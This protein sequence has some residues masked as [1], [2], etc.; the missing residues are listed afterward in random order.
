MSTGRPQSGVI[1][2]FCQSAVGRC[3]AVLILAALSIGCGTTQSRSATE[4]LLTS[5]A[6]DRSIARIDFR[7]LHGQKVFLDVDYVRNAKGVGSVNPDYI[8]S[9][10]RQQL[11]AAGCLLQENKHLA[12][13][14]VEPRVGAL[15]LDGHDVIYGIPAN[16]GLNAASALVPTMPSLPTIPELALAK[17]NDQRAASKIGVFAYHRV[18]REVVWQS[19]ISESLSTARDSWLM[20]AGPFQTGT[21]Y[22]EPKFVAGGVLIPTGTETADLPADVKYTEAKL[23][24]PPSSIKVPLPATASTPSPAAA[25]VTPTATITATDKKPEPATAEVPQEHLWQLPPTTASALAIP[26]QSATPA[27]EAS[28]SSTR[29]QR[30]SRRM[31]RSELEAELNREATIVPVSGSTEPAPFPD[32]EAIFQ[33]KLRA[34]SPPELQSAP[35]GK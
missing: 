6:V 18:T 4:Q 33:G 11:L 20:G 9:S 34:T 30:G 13:F 29:P 23:F 12:D 1:K 15:G 19:G 22:R 16:N 3:A 24:K 8:I 21:I 32:D 10:L 14:I 26:G 27:G 5:D 7:P 2:D 35:P 28:S 31:T 25:P 17:R